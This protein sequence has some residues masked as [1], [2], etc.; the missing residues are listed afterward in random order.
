[1][2]KK[3]LMKGMAALALLAGFSSCVK[4]VDSGS[5]VSPEDTDKT[6]KEVASLN[7]GLNI[8]DGQTWDM[9]TQVSANVNVNLTPGETY[10]VA[11]YANDPIADKKGVYLT[12][13]TVKNGGTFTSTFT[14]SSGA[15]SFVVGATDSKGI[16]RF[17]DGTVKNG[18][19][20]ADFGAKNAASR[21][22]R[23]ITVGKDT[24]DTF[25]FP[26]EEE[27]TAAFP[28][29]IPEGADEVVDL[30][31]MEK[32]NTKYYEYNNLYW[33]YLRN[34]AN[35]NYKVTK[36]G[37]AEIGGTYNNTTVGAYNVYVSVNGNV[38]LKRNGAELMNLYR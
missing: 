2:N 35:H 7:Y 20:T 38:T 18:V 17:T 21:S 32:Y 30:P 6:L 25:N 10:S 33:I 29:S 12:K 8:P 23:S 11:V 4:D 37:E 14:V 13:G 19:L 31:T 28:T 27:L 3:Y 26:T 1:M 15:Q 9:T 24:Y 36:T 22:M 34:G 16:T 5:R